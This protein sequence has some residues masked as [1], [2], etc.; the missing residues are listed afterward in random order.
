MFLLHRLIGL[1]PPELS[2]FSRG[3]KEILSVIDNSPVFQYI[4]NIEFKVP[5]L[6]AG[7]RFY[8]DQLGHKLIWR[9][10][11]AAGLKMPETQ[12]EIVLYTKHESGYCI[13]VQ[14]VNDAVRRIVAAG[15]K[16]VVPVFDMQIGR[17]AVVQDPWG[18]RFTI[19]D[20]SKGLFVTDANGNVT[21]TAPT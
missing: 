11:D 18:N 3:I 17:R 19:L 10:D 21:G 1:Y 14:D 6:E 9:T 4:D 12:T 16:V 2:P 20:F 8:R 7:L 15:G 5:D 13:K